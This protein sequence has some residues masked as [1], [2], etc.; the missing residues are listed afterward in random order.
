MSKCPQYDCS[1]PD[2]ID[3]PLEPYPDISGRGVIAGFVGT[4]YFVLILVLGNYFL[5]YDPEVSPFKSGPGIYH[6]ASVKNTWWRPNPVDVV[7]LRWLRQLVWSV[8]PMNVVT[9]WW[10]PRRARI[11][12]AFESCIRSLCD[13]Q[14]MT[15]IAILISGFSTV[16]CGL[17]SYHW[18]IVVYLAWFA[19]VTHLSGLTALRHYL[20]SR[21][22]EKSIRYILALALL[23][24]LLGA[25]IP[26][27]F[28][29]W[30]SSPETS[31]AKESTPAQ[32]FLDFTQQFKYYNR[33]EVGH[34][35]RRDRESFGETY[36]LQAMVFSSGLLIISLIT[37]TIKLFKSLTNIVHSRLQ[38]PLRDRIQVFIIKGSS[39][40][41]AALS[42]IRRKAYR[43][44]FSRN[45]QSISP[46]EILFK[47]MW[48]TV[49]L[50]LDVSNSMLGEI[51]WLL[52]L[53][54]W[55]TIRLV[56]SL[57]INDKMVSDAESTWAFGQILP[58]VLLVAPII[59]SIEA[60]A[61]ENISG[62]LRPPRYN[63]PRAR[64]DFSYDSPRNLAPEDAGSVTLAP[65]RLSILAP[66][67]EGNIAAATADD[68]ELDSG[69]T[70]DSRPIS[71]DGPN[72]DEAQWLGPCISSICAAVFTYTAICFGL[73]FNFLKDR[74]YEPQFPL[75]ET[76]FGGIGIFFSV[77]LAY[78]ATTMSTV[79]VGVYID[80]WNRQAGRQ[81]WSLASWLVFWTMGTVAY[82]VNLLPTILIFISVSA[83]SS[84][85]KY[86][87]YSKYLIPWLLSFALYGTAA[88]YSC[89]WGNIRLQPTSIA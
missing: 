36:A 35:C 3:L 84:T 27:A 73:T 50:N 5:A 11:A 76:W 74:T 2:W 44:K 54:V 24:G 85:E 6:H 81:H 13:I 60:F 87:N 82:L 33:C 51:Y 89:F 66:A 18:Q 22:W 40:M 55:G 61:P 12:D 64:R 42:L 79:F 43:R 62:S 26:T 20:H 65:L 46:T 67:S 47:A 30:R 75:V 78:P 59:T 69:A 71:L 41:Y 39:L 83:S 68:Q 7:F 15:G 9:K 38:R 16:N 14:L 77:L 86:L 10:E 34:F 63:W 52:V 32:C 58:V 31:I 29:D 53:L 80:F 25:V 57:A 1:R 17:S 88:L 49:S 45:K 48:I 4:T 19:C 8:V 56:S 21:P 37:R 70:A 28:F 72:Y 23:G